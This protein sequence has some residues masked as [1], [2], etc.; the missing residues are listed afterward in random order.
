V[1][2]LAIFERALTAN[3]IATLATRSSPLPE[4]APREWS[5]FWLRPQGDT[6]FLGLWHSDLPNSYWVLRVTEYAY[7]DP[8]LD[9]NVSAQDV[10]WT[11]SPD[12]KAA[13]FQWNAAEDLKR[14]VGLD[15]WGEY[16][17]DSDHLDFSITGKNV[18]Q[19]AWDRPRLSL[20][21]LISGAAPGFIDYEAERTF[22]RRGEQ[23]VTMNEIVGGEFAPHR[24]CGISVSSGGDQP[25]S[26]LAAKVSEDGKWVLGLAVD[27]A[28][29][30][31]FNFQKR[32]SCIHSNPAWPL[33]QPGEEATARGRAYL[34]KGTL[35]DLWQRYSEDF[36][37]P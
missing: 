10:A 26:R 34:L 28:G 3:E 8:E 4:I 35:D 9:R 16:T 24:M 7:F 14:R 37:K 19:E 1:D 29:S 2:E 11:V 27:R 15:F 31:S 21:C 20:V 13:Q 30:L 23:F 5:G 12:R 32:T 25:V 17:A 18:G 22:V 6:P 33:L 36:E